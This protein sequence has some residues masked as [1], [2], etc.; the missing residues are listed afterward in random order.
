MDH[1][2]NPVKLPQAIDAI[3]GSRDQN[4]I[5]D[6][7]PQPTMW[8]A[9]QTQRFSRTT[10]LKLCAQQGKDED[11]AVLTAIAQLFENGITPW[12]DGLYSQRRSRYTKIN[13]P[14]YP[15][16]SQHH[17]PPGLP[18]RN[19]PSA[20]PRY[21][22]TQEPT[23]H[24]F[25]IDK[26]LFDLLDEHRIEGRRVVPGAALA[27]FVAGLHSKNAVAS[28]QFHQPLILET[29]NITAHVSLNP[30]GSFS[31]FQDDSK[32]CSGNL[33]NAT[34]QASAHE[35]TIASPPSPTSSVMTHTEVYDCF[36]SVKFGPAF[37][38]ITTLHH[39][40][41]RAEAVIT[42][43]SS[44]NPTNDA[45]RKLDPCLHMFGAIVQSST[46]TS[47][48]TKSEGAFLPASLKNF[49]IFVDKLPSSFTCR[50]QLPLLVER[51][52][53][54]FSASFEV[55][56]LSGDVLASCEKYSVAWVPSGVVVQGSNQLARSPLWMR[57]LWVHRK[58]TSHPHEASPFRSLDTTIFVGNTLQSFM[59]PTHQDP[60]SE[61]IFIE[62]ARSSSERR[63]IELGSGDKTEWQ[64]IARLA[65]LLAGKTIT[66]ILEAAQTRDNPAS[67]AFAEFW[68]HVLW[69]MKL[70]LSLKVKISNFVLLSW[71]STTLWERGTGAHRGST[72]CDIPPP[73]LGAIAQGM[74]RVFRR[75][76]GL[77]EHAWGLDLPA[78]GPTTDYGV[79]VGKILGQE[80]AFR[81]A[82]QAN[83]TVVAYRW[84]SGQLERFV[85]QLNAIPQGPEVLVPNLKGGTCV[86]IG[87]GSIGAALALVLAN[88]ART[89]VFIGRRAIDH[90]EVGTHQ[91]SYGLWDLT[92]VRQVSRALSAIKDSGSTNAFYIRADVLDAVALKKSLG[93]VERQHG[94]IRHIIHTAAVI[95]DAT[96]NSITP[97]AFEA[98]I[99]PKA[100]G[101]WNLHVAAEELNLQ[102]DSFVLL[103]SIR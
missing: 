24:S 29:A 13:I 39:Y 37:Q 16:Q 20:P 31:M 71:V 26:S 94:A 73:S 46:E 95:S 84:K 34:I 88:A 21:Q 102:L 101:A 53:H 61:R 6:L 56:S 63:Y 81:E 48:P 72:S 51:N 100:L 85:P 2:R 64:D 96:I 28:I 41:D 14:T 87:L 7:G 68:K 86:I 47:R 59:R 1:A 66:V 45:I 9:L 54:V 57:N 32:I 4:I 74:L 44:G 99:R 80:L 42:V 38:G 55:L 93:Q 67:Q 83:D 70:L 36:T 30:D 91:I 35:A 90:P 19:S 8:S 52:Y 82:R 17:Y 23:S 11:V 97:E 22:E 43:P 75:E 77:E 27:A 40:P 10:S 69:L 3:D 50:Y 89:I 62:L 58:P 65:P 5:L 60:P 18:S 25:P 78:Q 76:T 33:T 12:F 79:D 92:L 15:F 103:S 98:V 49:S